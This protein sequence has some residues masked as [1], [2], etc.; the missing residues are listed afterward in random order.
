M[1]FTLIPKTPITQTTDPI[2]VGSSVIGIKYNKGIII[3]CD[4][5][6]NYGSLCKVMHTERISKI[7]ERTIIG[8]SGEY[9]DMQETLRTLNAM[10][11]EDNLTSNNKPFLGPIELTN[12]LS[13]L[14]YYKRNK[15]NP[16]LNNVICGGIDWNGDVVLLNIDPFG[17]LLNANY[18]TTSMSHYFC[19]AILRNEYPNDPKDINK[20]KAVEII[21]SC[22]E[23][24]FE[25]HSQA[26]NQIQYAIIEKNDNEG[27][28]IKFESG[29]FEL[30][31]RWDADMYKNK[32]NEFH[33]LIS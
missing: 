6:L 21:K 12:Y 4:T 7:T 17:T 23:V 29:E 15:M 19:N 2:Y 28:D 20:E 27:N 32:T 18:F 1:N 10:V 9:S 3:A 31:G 5:R 16:Y 25:R 33:Y 30:K 24:L 13:S 14:H 26:G 8:Y 11:L 22:F